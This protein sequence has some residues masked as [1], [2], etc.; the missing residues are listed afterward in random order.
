M[1]APATD[2]TPEVVSA[3]SD[4]TLTEPVATPSAPV[5]DIPTPPPSPLDAPPQAEQGVPQGSGPTPVPPPLKPQQ[6]PL[7]AAANQAAI[8]AKGR[9]PKQWAEITQLAKQFNVPADYVQ[10]NLEL[11]RSQYAQRQYQAAL[12]SGHPAVQ[13][14]ASD[15]TNATL[16]KHEIPALNRAAV[17][18][19]RLTDNINRDRDE[20]GQGVYNA[21]A[22]PLASGVASQLK[23]AYLLAAIYGSDAGVDQWLAKA[24]DA[25][26]RQMYLEQFAPEVVKGAAHKQEVRDQLYEGFKA[27][28][29]EGLHEFA[30]GSRGTFT[31][32]LTGLAH[33]VE[34]G[35]MTAREAL[36]NLAYTLD[37]RT[38]PYRVAQSAAGL[39]TPIAVGAAAAATGNP[40]AAFAGAVGGFIPLAV[41]GRLE[42]DLAERADLSNPA[43]MAQALADP[44]FK[45]KLRRDAALGGVTESVVMATIGALGGQLATKA[46]TKVLGATVPNAAKVAAEG[47]AQGAEDAA[48]AGQVRGVYQTAPLWKAKMAEHAVGALGNAVGVAAG[49]QVGNLVTG[50]ETSLNEFVKSTGEMLAFG[51]AMHLVHLRFGDSPVTKAVDATMTAGKAMDALRRASLL[52]EAGRAVREA[53]NTASQPD[54]MAELVQSVT[55]SDE[56]PTVYFQRAEWDK[57]MQAAGLDPEQTATEVLQDG[58]TG[59]KAAGEADAALAVPLD[60]LLAHLAPTEA[61]DKVKEIARHTPDGPT[62]AEAHAD[63]AKTEGELKG[64][65]AQIAQEDLKGRPPL[66]VYGQQLAAIHDEFQGQLQGQMPAGAARPPEEATRAAQLLTSMVHAAAS[67]LKVTPREAQ[68]MMLPLDFSRG[69]EGA[70][71]AATA[72]HQTATV[73]ARQETLER[74]GLDPNGVYTNR[75]VATALEARQRKQF[76]TIAWDDRSPEARDKIAQWMVAEILHEMQN[77]AQSGIGWYSEKFQRALDA[78]SGEFPELAHDKSARDLMTALIAITS[79]GAEVNE[80]FAMAMDAYRT[81]QRTGQFAMERGHSREASIRINLRNIQE[82]HGRL[83]ADG[84]RDYLLEE[85][86]ISQLT[87]EAKAMGLPF[88]TDYQAHIVMPRAAVVFGPK[89][90]AFYANLMGKANYLTMDRWWSRTFNR[91]RGQILT[92]PTAEGIANFRAMLGA[93]GKGLDDAAV[94]EATKPYQAAL[95]ERG[96]KTRL[97]Q[98]VG[99]SEPATKA[100]KAEWMEEA[101]AAAGKRF[102]AL[103]KEHNIER[104]ANT[105]HK[106]AF[107]EL[108]DIPKNA[109][110]RTFMLDT[111]ARAAE[112]LKAQGIKMSMADIQ[113]TLWYY[114]KKLYGQL[115]NKKSRGVVGTSYEEAARTLVQRGVESARPTDAGVREGA[116]NGSAVRGEDVVG[117]PPLTPSAESVAAT[118]DQQFGVGPA[119][120]TGVTPTETPAFKAWFG[121][122]KV[123][124][125]EGKPLIVYHGTPNGA[126]EFEQGREVWMT[127]SP[128]IADEYTSKRGAWLSRGEAPAIVPL[129]VKMERPLEIDAGGAK[130]NNIP[131]PWQAFTPT[132]FGNLP[133]NA[134]DSRAV[135]A[136]AKEHGYDGVVLRNLRDPVT[137]GRSKPSDI[138]VV[139]EPTQVKSAIGNRG[140]FEQTSPNVLFQRTVTAFPN[141]WS[142]PF[143]SKAERLVAEKVP[144]NATPAQ[145]LATLASVKAEERKWLGLDDFLNG[146]TTVDKAELQQWIAAN[147]VAMRLVEDVRGGERESAAYERL[148]DRAVQE[149]ID[150]EVEREL[151][152]AGNRDN[153]AEIRRRVTDRVER[154]DREDIR[155]EVLSDVYPEPEE[156]TSHGQWILGLSPAEESLRK[157]YREWLFTMPDLKGTPFI[158]E[159][160][161]GETENVIAH[162]RSI[163]REVQDAAGTPLG[164]ALHVEEVQSDLHRE[165]R[166][167]GYLTPELESE[168]TRTRT[169]WERS[170]A[171]LKAWLA[172]HPRVPGLG[173]FERDLTPDEK[174]T[175]DGLLEREKTLAHTALDA[176][177]KV[178]DAIPDAPFKKNWSE[179][180]LKRLIRHAAEQGLERITWVTG[181]QTQDRYALAKVADDIRYNPDTQ[182]F[183]ARKNGHLVD[184]R[185]V[186]PEGLPAVIGVDAAKRLLATERPR[187]NAEDFTKQVTYLRERAK[188]LSA[189]YVEAMLR[190]I[191][192]HTTDSSHE[193][194]RAYERK[195]QA[196]NELDDYLALGI[197]H[198][199]HSLEGESL[200]MG[201]EWAANL[202]DKQM[203]DFLRKF[204]KKFNAKVED[205]YLDT[206]NAEPELVHSMTIPDAMRDAALGEGFELFQRKVQQEQGAIQGLTLFR[207]DGSINIQFFEKAN[208]STVFHELAHYYTATLQQLSTVAPEGEAKARF[209]KDLETLRNWVGAPEGEALTVPQ[210]EQIARGFEQYLQEGKAPS[211]ALRDAFWRLR[212]WMLKLYKGLAVHGVQLTPEVRGVFDRMLATDAEIAEAER[213]T[214]STPLFGDDPKAMGLTD[215][216]AQ[217]LQKARDQAHQKAVEQQTAKRMKE[218][219]RKAGK[220]WKAWRDPIEKEVTAQV[221]ADP[222]QMAIAHMTKHQLPDGTPLSDDLVPPM[223]LS[224]AALV[225]EY[226]DTILNGLPKGMVDTEG[227]VPADVAASLYGF[228]NGRAFLDA[229]RTSEPRDAAIQR[230]TDAQMEAL[231]GEPLSNE[232]A[233]QSAMEYVAGEGQAAVARKELEIL[234]SESLPQAKGLIRTITKRIPPIEEIKLRAA[235]VIADTKVGA[236]RP[237]LFRVAASRAGNA[238]REALLKGDVEQ[239]VVLKKQEILATAIYEEALAQRDRV[240][241]AMEQMRKVF[242]SDKRLEGKHDLDYI[243]GARALLASLG[244]GT[245]RQ[246]VG[247]VEAMKMTKEYSPDAYE[248]VEALSADIAALGIRDWKKLTVAQF[249]EVAATIDQLWNLS[250]DAKTVTLEGRKQALQEAL[251]PMLEAAKARRV[252]RIAQRGIAKQL[253]PLEKGEALTL[254]FAA[255]LTRVESWARAMDGLNVNGPYSRI[256]RLVKDATNAFRLRQADVLPQLVAASEVL[257]GL[258]RQRDI[259]ASEIGYTFK[260]TNELLGALLHTGNAEGAGSNLEKLLVGR[261][262]AKKDAET[263]LVDRSQWDTFIRRMWKEGVLTQAHYDWVQAIWDTFERMKPDLQRAY[264]AMTGR[265]MVEVPHTGF[266]TPFGHYAGGYYPAIGD[267]SVAKIINPDGTASPMSVAVANAMRYSEENTLGHDS[268]F[269][270]VQPGAGMTKQ[271]TGAVYPLVIDATQVPRHLAATMKYIH[272]SVPIRDAFKVFNNREFREVMDGINP[273]LVEGALMPFLKAAGS[274]QSSAPAT[275][276]AGRNFEKGLKWI[277][278]GAMRSLVAL[279]P[280]ILAEQVA[281]LATIQSLRTP[282]NKAV[283]YYPD[284]LRAMAKVTLGGTK[285]TQWIHDQSPT[286]ATRDHRGLERAMLDYQQLMDPSK[287]RTMQEETTH[288]LSFVSHVITSLLDKSVWLGV[289]DRAIT[290]GMEADAARHVADNAVREGLGGHHAEDVASVQ[291]SSAIAKMLQ[292]F[293][294]FY[295][296]KLNQFGAD[297]FAQTMTEAGLKRSKM[298]MAAVYA[299]G[300]AMMGITG[301][302]VRQLMSGKKDDTEDNESFD[303]ALLHWAGWALD[304]QAE[305]GFALFPYTG[306]FRGIYESG[307]ALAQ[308]HRAGGRD[309]TLASPFTQAGQQAVGTLGAV[310][311]AARGEDITGKDIKDALGLF[312]TLSHIPTAVIARPLAYT[313]DVRQG[314]ATPEGVL[315]YT[316]GLLTGQRGGK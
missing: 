135:V 213:D 146:K 104:A 283:V 289:Y 162:G 76:G 79:D 195:I 284:V 90:G 286:V 304:A 211:A 26:T 306:A 212:Q 190:D 29:A 30:D 221:D 98:M 315:D 253:T 112:L 280:T 177:A 237:D 114:E 282:D 176:A 105:L 264:L 97:A 208:K 161:W 121:D 153:E 47:F 38:L 234:V 80:N 78:M 266:D 312:G 219:Q 33:A 92:T 123:V 197:G 257:R 17:A 14:W 74:Y 291:R 209:T 223:K 279:N 27:L 244:I 256:V 77:P 137:A 115:G 169:E 100:G 119:A 207:P 164:R 120:V 308:G 250:T 180:V 157:T 271:R 67:T 49:Q 58:G 165:G 204:G 309:N 233:K 228:E 299:L 246:Q 175:Y 63:L 140:T 178:R 189:D 152:R 215:A 292:G 118:G 193:V 102:A 273:E 108:E 163:V 83:G 19:Q 44:A 125:A 13:S 236:V 60:K 96:F 111:T 300:F 59:Y 99:R 16:A 275:T 269:L 109:T 210:H 238:A 41:G 103:L 158:E 43:A 116:D 255:S 186:S 37:P 248:A 216:Q 313:Q 155:Q 260:D 239:A 247:A 281:H 88:K 298:R 62:T 147:N 129:Y 254:S 182:Q 20:E 12:A 245:E 84:M 23:Q 240:D 131:V 6:K 252:E 242:R 259:A 232:A 82:L 310:F 31:S 262:W 206:G 226:G 249:D 28:T 39:A 94:L 160:H 150:D 307:K 68:A 138:Y 56:H 201:G 159:A 272:L 181:E 227:G 305:T 72:L 21:L 311:H 303:D 2:L 75:E 274:Q 66:T 50:K 316:R 61:W 144:N 3:A 230:L 9:D 122:S 196:K 54:R 51:E 107:T 183:E 86:P 258:P 1:T 10:R 194:N 217:S 117:Q 101:K 85:V 124:D 81:F 301:H 173:V 69:V 4:Q 145:I 295:N 294:G 46:G 40:L 136:W 174:R 243:N 132:T 45:A 139:F 128:A 287:L 55:G 64:A 267:Q 148:V 73:A 231:H 70:I 53:P 170:K 191:A 141:A 235:A 154:E 277:R 199:P 25:H 225:A 218:L 149:R 290:R 89:L 142:P 172:D 11:V 113:A 229:V 263:G 288:T 18:A 224:K 127:N 214:H 143:Y 106:A 166:K 168:A 95:E 220:Q 22:N 34:G 198:L 48:I 8:I 52:E 93:K 156:S 251:A 296:A 179:F 202:Y 91:Y 71:E 32:R 15:A 278:T 192:A 167:Q 36:V 134:V 200:R 268:K 87:K 130:W 188:T 126:V 205:V 187:V 184:V 276:K 24:G 265:H 57:T 203:T 302:G 110:D 293:Y 285:L 133:R 35:A 297:A 7:D 270:N 65:L 171:D 314:R 222:V 151:T 5:A 261:G 42:R 185:K 241:A